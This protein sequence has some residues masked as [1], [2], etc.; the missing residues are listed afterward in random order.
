MSY[1]VVWRPSAEAAL[2]SLWVEASDRHAVTNA[3]PDV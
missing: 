2:A 3:G 1:T